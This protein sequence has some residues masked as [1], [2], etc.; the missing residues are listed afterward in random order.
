M[1]RDTLTALDAWYDWWIVFWWDHPVLF[2]WMA[3]ASAAF[4]VWTHRRKP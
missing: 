2:A 1:I 4:A 3:V